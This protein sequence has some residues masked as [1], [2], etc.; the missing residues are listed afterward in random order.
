[1]TMT[2]LYDKENRGCAHAVARRMRRL[3]ATLDRIEYGC[4][5]R[6]AVRSAW[7][8]I[9]FPWFKRSDRFYVC[10]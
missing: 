3:A 5:E 4:R 2:S 6:D 7:K 8:M 9:V 10:A 1:M